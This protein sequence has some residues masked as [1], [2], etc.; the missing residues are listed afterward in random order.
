[1]GWGLITPDPAANVIDETLARLG[2][3]GKAQRTKPQAACD[4]MTQNMAARR[5]YWQNAA[6]LGEGF[7]QADDP[8]IYC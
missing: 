4:F 2:I 3:A 5:G 1:M 6:V 7:G 8:Y